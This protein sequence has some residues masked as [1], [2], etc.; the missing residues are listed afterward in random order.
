M[1]NLIVGSIS[2]VGLI[3]MVASWRL[4]S[5]FEIP[6]D[7][8]LAIAVCELIENSAI[9][10]SS[11]YFAV[12]E[13]M[14][15]IPDNF[16]SSCTAIGVFNVIGNIGSMIYN[17]IFCLILS[18]SIKK[19]LKG[20]LFNRSKYHAIGLITTLVAA[21]SL[22]LSDNIGRGLNGICGYRM[23]SK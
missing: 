12:N 17:L 19:T 4:Y 9:L 20:S 3:L 7:I 2:I 5:S 22:V 1:F 13:S 6:S 23:A 8:M 16:E 10:A 14:E 21:A 18:F 15:E 11:A